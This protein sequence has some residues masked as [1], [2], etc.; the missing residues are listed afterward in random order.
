MDFK[1][2]FHQ[3]GQ[4]Y[5]N[6]NRKQRIVIAA[7]IVIVVAFL[8]FL[9][10][11]RNSGNSVQ[12]GY[13][14]LVE[15]VNPSSS[16][17]IVSKL[18][19]NGVPYILQNENTILVPQDQVYRQRMFIASEGL[20][21]DTRIGFEAFNTPTFGATNKEETIK[22]QRAVEGELAR[23]I[24]TLEPIRSA[25]VHIAFPKESVFTER[26]V[27]PTASI[28]V[29]IKEGLKLTSKQIDG[30]KNIVSAAVA[31]LTKENVHIVDQNGVPL[32]EQDAYADDLIRAQIKYKSDQEKALE[33]KIINSLAPFAGGRNN[34]EVS[35]NIDFDFSKQE[36]QS[37]VYDPN[38]V[39]R[40]EQTLKE[41]RTGRQEPQT[42]GVPG[43]ITNVGP[44]EGLDNKGLV[45]TYNKD[46]V[47]TNNEI[48][49]TI[50]NT[51]KQFATIIRTSAAV[52]IDG[53][54]KEVTDENGNIKSEYVPLSNEEL[55]KLENLVKST[56]NYNAARGDSVVVS[57]LPF[58]RESVK[59][60]NRVKTF[61]NTYVEPF[62]PP[63]KYILAAILL[64][65]FYKKIIAPFAQK[66]LEDVAA[67]EAQNEMSPIIDDAEDALEKF[68][69]A[70][71][72]VEEQLGF[73][74]NFNEDS[75]QY[76]VLLEKLRALVNDKSEEIAVLLQNLIQNDVEFAENKDI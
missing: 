73:G 2:M 27:P 1:N 59:V 17:A 45:E 53:K 55:Q 32:D 61:Y 5:Q 47:T 33:E 28:T 56:I 15:G 71:K 24:E 39:V 72:K 20:I 65:I 74:D 10:L 50:T 43:A 9:A 8:V 13:A 34:L 25:V 63:V 7:S 18:E 12:G 49:K 40:S 48:S 46:Q 3:I 42:Q 19:Q 67:E 69:A 70:K 4:L 35:V 66:M 68:N 64:F 21:K 22:Y 36:S 23:T 52:T 31:K 11:Y 60:E 58:Q 54:Y 37:E 14:V 30:I 75:I 51:Q 29:N 6:L 57:N 62:I 44:V 38:T 76:E 16:A 41:Q 26:Q